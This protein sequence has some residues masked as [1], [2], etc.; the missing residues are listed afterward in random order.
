LIQNTAFFLA[1]FA[2]LQFAGWGNKE[3][4]GFAICGSIITNLRFPDWHTS[5]ICGFAIAEL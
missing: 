1:D 2:E 4:C 3:I 5:E